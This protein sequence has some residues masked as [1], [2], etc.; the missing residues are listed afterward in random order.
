M[1]SFAQTIGGSQPATPLDLTEF[2]S[3]SSTP[4]QHNQNNSQ[5]TWANA[6]QRNATQTPV[7]RPQ[8]Q[9]NS[10]L[11]ALSH[12][13]QQSQSH[14]QQSQ[15]QQQQHQQHQQ[16]QQQQQHQQQ[17]SIFPT[18]SQFSSNL[19]DF[20]FGGQDAIGQLPGSS[21]PKTGSIDDFP[22]LGRTGNGDLGQERR[23]SLIQNAGFGGQSNTSGIGFGPGANQAQNLPIRSGILGSIS[24]HSDGSRNG[25]V[26]GGVL[27]PAVLGSG[28][29]SASRSPIESMRQSQSSQPDQD[30]NVRSQ[31]DCKKLFNAD[32]S[33]DHKNLSRPVQ[34]GN[35]IPSLFSN[36]QVSQPNNT[37]QPPTQ[38]SSFPGT[39]QQRQTQQQQQGFGGDFAESPQAAQPSDPLSSMNELDRFGLTGLLQMIRNE[40][41]DT[42]SLA[43]G[44]DLTALGLDLN[45]PDNSPLYPTFA[46]PFAEAGSRPVEPDFSVPACYTVQNIQSLSSKVQSFSDETLFYIFYSMTKDVMQEVV[47]AELTTR[48]WRYHKEL[49]QWLTKDVS[50]EPQ[51]INAGEERGFYIFFDPSSWQRQRREFLLHYDSLDS[52]SFQPVQTLPIS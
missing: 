51:R 13:Q 2:P 27:S 5:S 8:P 24:G 39:Q 11:N 36:S 50:Y 34:N 43:I 9:S 41:S 40:G 26:S 19:D 48:N 33:L 20:R 49:K 22:P 4:A 29:M 52:R 35:P 23:S 42:G 45:Q 25:G 6:T 30:R 38:Q 14:H 31:E 32:K 18:S 10:G 37:P 12:L 28:G 15:Q 3:L 1:T 46:S 17:E 16:Q 7:Q 21:Q 47:A 44:Q